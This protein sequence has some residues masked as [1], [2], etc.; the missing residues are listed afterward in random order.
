[1]EFYPVAI[2]KLIEEFAKLP[3]IGKKSAQRLT[4]HIL[5][6]P[7]DE[8]EEFA[9]ALVKARGTIKYCSVC[10]NFTDTDPCAICSNPNRE[11]DIIC[12]VEQPKD[13]MT[14]EKVKE[15]NGLYHVLHGT[16]SPMQ[17][18]GPQDIRI[19]E[20]V[21]RMSGDVKEVIVATNPT[22]EGEATA[23]YISKILKPLDVKVTRIA[24]GI[25]VGGDLEYADEVTLSKALE[26][27]TLI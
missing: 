16:I 17:G 5:N 2:E 1:M 19:R 15:F 24:A 27:R 26:G 10:G 4:L 22:I 25:P 12:V 3:S 18:R 11:K 7:K 9:N 20:L 23:M 6:L 14:M 8:V 21:A 13:I